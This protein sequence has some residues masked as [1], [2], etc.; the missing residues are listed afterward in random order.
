MISHQNDDFEQLHNFA[1]DLKNPIGAAKSFIELAEASGSLNER[2]LHFLQR[3]LQNLERANHIITELLD[4]ARMGTSTL[5][6]ERC[7]LATMID[8]TLRGVESDALQ[9]NLKVSVDLAANAR[10]VL[11]DARLLLHILQNLI[12]N[13][14][15]YNRHGGSVSI[16]TIEQGAFVLIAVRDT[17][18]GIPGDIQERVFERFFRA[19]RRIERET[20]GTGLG[21]AIVKSAVERLGGMVFLESEEGSGSVFSITL[22]QAESSVYE[23]DREPSDSVDDS[24]QEM[25]EDLTSSD[26]PDQY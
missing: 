14:V 15:K 13:A 22:P 18:V 4:L 19:D 25:R 9:K 24:R 20:E 10:Y 17:G 6:T 26:S 11:A 5:V 23:Q 7:D 12:T 8:D 21:L 1:H 16:S 2:Q 3:A